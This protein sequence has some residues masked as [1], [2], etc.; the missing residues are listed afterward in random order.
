MLDEQ[1]QSIDEQLREMIAQEVEIRPALPEVQK[2][3]LRR[4]GEERY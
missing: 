4:E 1:L 2:T 3:A